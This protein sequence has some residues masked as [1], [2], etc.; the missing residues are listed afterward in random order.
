MNTC[1]CGVACPA[2]IAVEGSRDGSAAGMVPLCAPSSTSGLT[3]IKI[4]L[5]RD[6]VVSAV[7]VRLHKPR[8]SQTVGLS[9]ILLM[10]TM[11]FG[12]VI[13]AT[14]A[15]A[16]NVLQPMEDYVAKTRLDLFCC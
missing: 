3:T 13:A 11:A 15:R 16:A 10:G 1:C 5:L 9:Q 14:A 2:A 12:D 4:Q 8:D 7:T 6:E